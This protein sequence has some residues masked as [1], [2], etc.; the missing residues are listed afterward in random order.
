MRLDHPAPSR[1]RDTTASTMRAA[2]PHGRQPQVG[3]VGFREARDVHGA[4]GQ[5]GA[6][7]DERGGGD[8]AGVVVL[9]D[10]DASGGQEPGQL[11]GPGRAR[12]DAAGVV[13]PGLDEERDRLQLQPPGDGRRHGALVVEADRD[14]VGAEVAE[15]VEQRRE[16]RVLDHDPVTEAHDL[17]RQPVEGVEA[18][19]DHGDP[20]RL[21]RP[22]L[23]QGVVEPR[24]DG[25]VEVVGGEVAGRGTGSGVAEIGQERRVGDAGRE[26]EGVDPRPAGDP[27]VA[28]GP[29]GRGLRADERAGP[30]PRLDGAGAGQGLPRL[31]HRRRADAQPGGHRAHGRQALA[32][33]Q[34]ARADEPPDRPGDAAGAAV[35]DRCDQVRVVHADLAGSPVVIPWTY[36]RNRCLVTNEECPTAIVTQMS[37]RAGDRGNN[38]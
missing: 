11:G 7:A 26:V 5:P 4:V 10:D 14:H 23:A 2:P 1:R 29:V 15:Q 28:L 37:G 25:V 18:A 24:V 13:G 16:R 30:A 35:G 12:R 22:A 34:G 19:V 3:A 27:P 8:V 6:Q 9:H 32:G 38:V 36:R 31:P 33:R 20:G 17:G 21:E